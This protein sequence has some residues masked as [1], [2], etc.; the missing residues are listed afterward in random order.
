MSRRSTAR[1]VLPLI[2]GGALVAGTIAVVGTGPLVRGLLA[3][4]PAAILG[5]LLL[6]AAATCAAAWRWRTVSSELGLP[7]TWPAAVA[8]Y[9]RSQFINTVLPGGVLGDVHRAYRQG[10]RRADLPMA[11]RAVATERVAG[12]VVQAAVTVGVLAAFGL[13]SSMAEGMPGEWAPA[14]WAP[15]QW[16]PAEWAPAGW[17]TAGAAG[18]LAALV[19]AGLIVVRVNGRARR[20]VQ[21][22][23]SLLRT[24]FRRPRSALSIAAASLVVV[25]AHV[26]TF[27]VACLAVGIQVSALELI[28]LALL[29]LAAASLPLNV[30]G[31]GPREAASAAA[32]G[33]IGLGAGAGLAASTAFGVLT[34]VAVLPGAVVLIAGLAGDLI[35]A[36]VGAIPLVPP[37]PEERTA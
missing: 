35:R 27:V 10:S 13:V 36:R 20:L 31:W 23:L 30:G 19:V 28:G 9:Y 15:A 11:A 12:Q 7:M 33:A 6:T 34:F 1:R 37:L 4:S 16:A 25:A 32:F 2:F 29:A 24:V 22:E 17:V 8:A 26:G 21:R 18:L 5:A 14:Q 3:V